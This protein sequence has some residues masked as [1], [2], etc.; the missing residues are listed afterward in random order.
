M[1]IERPL[2]EIH[3]LARNTVLWNLSV[4]LTMLFTCGSTLIRSGEYLQAGYYYYDGYVLLSL[5]LCFAFPIFVIIYQFWS[6]QTVRGFLLLLHAIGAVI[7]FVLVDKYLELQTITPE[8]PYI[9]AGLFLQQNLVLIIMQCLIYLLLLLLNFLLL[10]TPRKFKS[11][12]L[13]MGGLGDEREDSRRFT[14]N[15]TISITAAFIAVAV[16]LY[17]NHYYGLTL[18]LGVG[19]GA[20]ILGGILVWWTARGIYVPFD[21]EKA[22]FQNQRI[23]DPW[24]IKIYAVCVAFVMI[25][26]LYGIIN[27][28]DLETFMFIGIILSNFFILGLARLIW[29]VFSRPRKRSDFER[30]DQYQAVINS[31]KFYLF[32]GIYGGLLILTASMLYHIDIDRQKELLA[33]SRLFVALAVVFLVIFTLWNYISPKIFHIVAWVCV[34]STLYIQI[35]IAHEAMTTD[36][37]KTPENVLDGFEFLQ[38]W[39]HAFLTAI[40]VSVVFASLIDTYRR[41]HLRTQQHG[42][43]FEV[44]VIFFFTLMMAG[45]IFGHDHKFT[46]P[47]ANEFPVNAEKLYDLLSLFF[48]GVLIITLFTI[49]VALWLSLRQMLIQQGLKVGS[50]ETYKQYVHKFTEGS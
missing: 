17:V 50:K 12:E 24:G 31:D 21:L 5:C 43:H 25:L 45:L 19:Y 35:H 27:V 30:V 4:A 15:T 48:Y 10:I 34:L 38:S 18:W 6:F 28:A 7:G 1:S 41:Y 2:S 47:H 39:P 44:Q 11:K 29:D 37:W 9:L 40:P 8:P 46:G 22:T 33:G 16:S 36:W 14:Q 32:Y 20:T 42:I 49:L 26:T 13:E 23:V 3:P